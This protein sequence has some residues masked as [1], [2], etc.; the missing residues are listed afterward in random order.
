M[1]H[2]PDSSKGKKR[3]RDRKDTAFMDVHRRM[4][5]YWQ[6]NDPD[7]KSRAGSSYARKLRNQR[8]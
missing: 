7:S 5:A 1:S 6:E 8:K 4:R 3:D 2:P